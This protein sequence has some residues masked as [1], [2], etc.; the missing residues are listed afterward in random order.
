MGRHAGAGRLHPADRGDLSP[1]SPRHADRGRRP[2]RRRA[3]RT[4]RP[5][6]DPN[7]LRLRPGPLL[8]AAG[9]PRPGRRLPDLRPP[10]RRV[11]PLCEARLPHR[12]Q[13]DLGD[14]DLVRPGRRSANRTRRRTHPRPR[15]R[16]R[17]LSQRPSGDALAVLDA[18]GDGRI[19]EPRPLAAIG[20]TGMS[21]ASGPMVL[22]HIGHWYI[23]FVVWLGP[24]LVI[25]VPFKLAERRTPPEDAESDEWLSKAFPTRGCPSGRAFDGASGLRDPVKPLRSDAVTTDAVA[26]RRRRIPTAPAC[27]GTAGGC[28]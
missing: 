3:R 2:Q 12:F 11:R 14:G 25:A 26:M 27:H 16:G 9:L 22:S 20:G 8:L 5:Y 28:V 15:P 18:G 4:L 17:A 13:P 21:A 1:G 24:V 19:H 6:P 23:D 7:R 10:G